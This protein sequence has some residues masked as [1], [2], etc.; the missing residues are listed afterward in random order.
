MKKILIKI[1]CALIPFKP[2][3]IYIRGKERLFNLRI[4]SSCDIPEIKQYRRNGVRFPHPVGI[5]ISATTLIE[6]N[7]TI[8]QNVT[9]GSKGDYNEVDLTRPTIKEGVIIYAGAVIVGDITLGKNSVIAANS[10][11]SISV[12]ENSIA[13]G[14]N[15]VK[16]KNK[17]PCKSA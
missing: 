17:K 11:I 14:C 7:V 8:Y 13:Y 15:K 6:K 3:R 16:P 4:K 2:L 12:P 5:V 1:I 10:F 9:I